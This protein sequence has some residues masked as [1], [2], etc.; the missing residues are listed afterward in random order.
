MLIGRAQQRE[1]WV[2]S[3]LMNVVE[4]DLDQNTCYIQPEAAR[5][6]DGMVVGGMAEIQSLKPHLVKWRRHY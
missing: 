6:F 3:A 2:K 5:D 4:K 1:G